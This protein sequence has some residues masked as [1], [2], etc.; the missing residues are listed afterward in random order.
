MGAAL[1]AWVRATTHPGGRG[2]F[3]VHKRQAG[4]GRVA[5]GAMDRA[6]WG[7]DDFGFPVSWQ[8]LWTG[9][10]RD[11]SMGPEPLDRG[12]SLKKH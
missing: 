10:R 11:S 5:R 7:S 8:D 2:A 3:G 1:A 6:A 4:L 12:A 9:S